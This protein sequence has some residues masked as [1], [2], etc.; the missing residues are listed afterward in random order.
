MY[1]YDIAINKNQ[2]VQH[3]LNA[4]RNVTNGEVERLSCLFNSNKSNNECDQQLG[5][6]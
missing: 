3:C 2:F 4:A 1:L 5:T 6:E